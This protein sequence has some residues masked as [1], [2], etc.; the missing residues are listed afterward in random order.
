[1][2]SSLSI[3]Y[4]MAAAGAEPGLD[5]E[6]CPVIRPT[7]SGARWV[8]AKG[9]AL[10]SCAGAEIALVLRSL[11]LRRA[12]PENTLTTLDPCSLLPLDK[13]EYLYIAWFIQFLC[14]FMFVA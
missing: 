8:P 5:G 13:I 2:L 6:A 10:R 14:I 1:M 11:S 12:R 4:L 3:P 7:L 9:C